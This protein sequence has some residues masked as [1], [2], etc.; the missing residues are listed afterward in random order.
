ML[1]GVHADII[2]GENH[3]ISHAEA[4][5]IPASHQGGA[6]RRANGCRVET[7]EL[8]PLLGQEVEG[9]GVDVTAVIAHIRPT[10]II[11]D[12]HQN[13]GFYR[14]L[15]GIFLRNSLRRHDHEHRKENCEAISYHSHWSPPINT[16]TPISL[17]AC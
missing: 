13:I 4:N 3:P 2:P 10:K 8:D 11:S 7:I 1:I 9:R 5:R 12:H 14:R 15:N 16:G 6:G 17:I